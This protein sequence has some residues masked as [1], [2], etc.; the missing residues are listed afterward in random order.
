MTPALKLQTPLL[1]PE[2]A[3][4]LLAVKPSWIYDAVRSGKLPC[5]RIGR[6][7]RFTQQP[8]DDL[9]RKRY[10]HLMLHA[11]EPTHRP[12]RIV[13]VAQDTPQGLTRRI[14][15]G[16][17][18]SVRRALWAERTLIKTFGPRGTIHLLPTSALPMW[19]GALSARM[20]A[21]S[22]SPTLGL[23]GTTATPAANAPTTAT[24]V[25]IVGVAH[26]AT[27]PASSRFAIAAAF[28]AS[29]R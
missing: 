2:E 24:Q 14:A 27:R 22:R 20:W 18:T 7:I 13:P 10:Q 21:N 29:S 1:R 26:T 8:P 19:T 25:S 16:T 15:G 17:R 23:I 9:H 28:P 12:P 6:H 11:R 5:V 3:A 4:K